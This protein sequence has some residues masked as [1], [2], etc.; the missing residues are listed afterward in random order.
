MKVSHDSFIVI[1]GFGR[2]THEASSSPKGQSRRASI[3][4]NALRS[5]CVPG[6]GFRSDE[7]QDISC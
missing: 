5:K 3:C 4:H 2:V 1:A 6:L 7:S